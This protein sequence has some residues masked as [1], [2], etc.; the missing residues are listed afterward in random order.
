ME[1]TWQWLKFMITYIETVRFIHSPVPDMYT[2]K[3]GTDV[4]K[5][6]FKVLYKP[7]KN[8]CISRWM[9]CVVNLS[10]EEFTA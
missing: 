8:P 5:D 3:P 2:N 4:L 1:K 10:R 6:Q 7:I 9:V